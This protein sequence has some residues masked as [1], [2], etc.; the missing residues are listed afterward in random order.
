MKGT[1]TLSDR[2]ARRAYEIF[3]ARG[4]QHGHDWADWFQAEREIRLTETA[5]RLIC[6]VIG[7][8]NGGSPRIGG[9]ERLADWLVERRIH[10]YDWPEVKNRISLRVDERGV[11][12]AHIDL[13]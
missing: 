11:H 7:H 5:E 10:A 13:A 3:Q 2:I 4:Q 6:A 1:P 8:L 9:T 12:F